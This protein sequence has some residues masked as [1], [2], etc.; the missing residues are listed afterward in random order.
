[1]RYIARHFFGYRILQ[2]NAMGMENHCTMSTRPICL[3]RVKLA[4]GA[5]PYVE[6][7]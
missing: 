5:V 7:R 3:F 6:A 1:M 4:E 2:R